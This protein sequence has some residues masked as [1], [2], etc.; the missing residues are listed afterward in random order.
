[1]WIVTA[2]DNASS[3]C[4]IK[5]GLVSV[6][7]LVACILLLYTHV[8]Q[9]TLTPSFQQVSMNLKQLFAYILISIAMSLNQIVETAVHH[10]DGLFLPNRGFVTLCLLPYWY[11]MLSTDSRSLHSV[12]LVAVACISIIASGSFLGSKGFVQ[13]IVSAIVYVVITASML[14]CFYMQRATLPSMRQP[15]ALKTH[16]NSDAEINQERDV[17]KLQSDLEEMRYILTNVAHDLKTVCTISMYILVC[18]NRLL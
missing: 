13:C 10:P 6:L 15:S 7:L 4:W 5:A 11:T 16:E 17:K 9:K 18:A 3:L 1:M 8:I 14:G 2:I 12:L